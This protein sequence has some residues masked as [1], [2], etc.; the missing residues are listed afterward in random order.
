MGGREPRGNECVFRRHTE[1]HYLQYQL[2]GCLVLEISTGDRD[3][4]Y[5]FTVVFCGR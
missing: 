1:V 2:D 3:G 5:R 4:R